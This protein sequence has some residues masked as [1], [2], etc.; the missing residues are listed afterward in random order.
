VG[1]SLFDRDVA[2]PQVVTHAASHADAG[3][4]RPSVLLPP[5]AIYPAA[6]LQ[7]PYDC[8]QTGYFFMIFLKV[9]TSDIKGNEPGATLLPGNILSRLGAPG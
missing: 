6:T 8:P 7:N 2:I 4:L 5:A 1:A 3:C 9:G